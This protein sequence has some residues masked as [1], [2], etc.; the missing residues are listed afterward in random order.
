MIHECSKI[1]L[2]WTLILYND[3]MKYW[4]FL[5]RLWM[6]LIQIN[7]SNMHYN[8]TF[9]DHM[10]CLENKNLENTF[11]LCVKNG[12]A[13]SMWFSDKEMLPSRFNLVKQISH[14]YCTF[15]I[16]WCRYISALLKFY[17]VNP[18]VVSPKQRTINVELWCLL[19]RSLKICWTKSLGT[20]VLINHG[21]HVTSLSCMSPHS[22]YIMAYIWCK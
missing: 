1:E 13:F 15:I 11:T 10:C 5:V 4:V 8:W 16:S 14:E 7:V 6:A 17:K 3:F 19:C 9:D 18:Q 21:A 2:N 22:L 20:G 12:K